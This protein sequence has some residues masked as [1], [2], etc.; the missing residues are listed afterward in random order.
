M[1]S[2]KALAVISDVKESYISFSQCNSVIRLPFQIRA[3][4][5]WSNSMSSFSDLKKLKVF[6][7]FT[8]DA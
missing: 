1:C 8:L 2:N 6:E 7:M 5:L 4:V 3:R